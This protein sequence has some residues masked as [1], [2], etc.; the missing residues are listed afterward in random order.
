LDDYIEQCVSEAKRSFPD[1]PRQTLRASLTG[2]LSCLC[3]AAELV[4]SKREKDREIA[5]RN[6]G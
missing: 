1:L 2:N 5:S 3:R 6:G 4:I